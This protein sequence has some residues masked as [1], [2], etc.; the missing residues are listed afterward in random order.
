MDTNNF[1]EIVKP[2][3]QS[4]EGNSPLS[5]EQGKGGFPKA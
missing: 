2:L 4:L 5:W 1:A 3:H